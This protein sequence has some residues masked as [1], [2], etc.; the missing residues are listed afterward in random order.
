LLLNFSDA[1]VN[2]VHAI[3]RRSAKEECNV[4]PDNTNFCRVRDGACQAK[5]TQW[6]TMPVFVWIYK[7][8]HNR[9]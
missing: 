1:P 7:F 3:S 2:R 6:Y 5:G 9:P 8:V 4:L